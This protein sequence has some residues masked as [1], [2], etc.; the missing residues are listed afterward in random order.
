MTYD[1]SENHDFVNKEVY[2]T[3]ILRLSCIDCG[4]FSSGNKVVTEEVL[5]NAT[6]RRT[7]SNIYKGNRTGVKTC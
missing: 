2:D 5:L 6:Y 4:S 3:F 1:T 7:T